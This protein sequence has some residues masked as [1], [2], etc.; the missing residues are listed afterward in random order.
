MQ[1]L[2]S[3]TAAQHVWSGMRLEYVPPLRLLVACLGT[4]FWNDSLQSRVS[5]TLKS[6]RTNV[7]CS[8]WRGWAV[9]L[10]G[11]ASPSLLTP[12]Q[13]LSGQLLSL[14]SCSYHSRG[15]LPRLKCIFSITYVPARIISSL[16]KWKQDF[17]FIV[18]LLYIT[19]L[20]KCYKYLFIGR[21][22]SKAILHPHGQATIWMVSYLC[23]KWTI[24]EHWWPSETS[25]VM[26][27]LVAHQ[28][29]CPQ[30]PD[31]SFG[32]LIATVTVSLFVWFSFSWISPCLKYL[33]L[34]GLLVEV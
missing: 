23:K 8:K 24:L 20:L 21:T 12:P 18:I 26:R 5:V 10:H 33:F 25:P 28:P 16:I 22:S 32:L 13:G 6:V 4:R 3:V 19:L 2:I 9:S 34:N 14:C 7:G 29:G 15:F 11:P 31:M 27:L 1:F 30:H 17:R